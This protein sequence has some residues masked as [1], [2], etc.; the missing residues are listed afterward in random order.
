MLSLH[1]LLQKQP[2]L[3]CLQC[4]LWVLGTKEPSAPVTSSLGD[5]VLPSQ[6]KQYNLS[7]V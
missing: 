6:K 5:S 1:G 7:T 2:V 4:W 3:Y